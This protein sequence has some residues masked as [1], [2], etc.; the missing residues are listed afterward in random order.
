M[1]GPGHRQIHDPCDEKAQKPDTP[2]RAD[3]NMSI[4]ATFHEIHH[5]QDGR[6]IEFELRVLRKG[7][8]THGGEKGDPFTLRRGFASRRDDRHCHPPIPG[9]PDES[10]D[11][12][13]HPVDVVKSIREEGDL[14][15]GPV[16]VRP[17][18]LRRQF[19]NKLL[20][21]VLVVKGKVV[22]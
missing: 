14:F 15:P 8:V 19:P 11:G 9:N 21:P 7:K 13:C 20:A 6:K 5:I 10:Q 1:I 17:G 4:P 2:R 16:E 3:M 22:G 12:D 18:K